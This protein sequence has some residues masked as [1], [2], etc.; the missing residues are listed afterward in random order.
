MNPQSLNRYTYCLNNPLKYID[1]TGFWGESLDNP[2]DEGALGWTSAEGWLIGIGGE[3]IPI[4]EQAVD[5]MI[6]EF[7]ESTSDTWSEF[8]Q[9]FGLPIASEETPSYTWGNNISKAGETGYF[10][11]VE[12]RYNR[13]KDIA[14]QYPMEPRLTLIENYEMTTQDYILLCDTFAVA[15]DAVSFVPGLGP[16]GYS[17]S[18]VAS[19][20]GY[21]L[22]VSEYR[23]GNIT[24]NDM[25]RAHINWTTG[26]IP[27][28]GIIPAGI[29]WNWDR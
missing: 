27:G 4:A 19:T 3:W 14:G 25:L 2:Y 9:D 11:S 20:V 10:W 26:F 17:V 7:R 18:A 23:K 22:S 21:G 13:E 1:P 12:S 16:I 6:S 24:Q 5:T 29:Q 28:W 8:T 15:G